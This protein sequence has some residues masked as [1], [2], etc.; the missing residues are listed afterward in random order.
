[1]PHQS[2]GADEQRVLAGFHERDK[3][4][5]AVKDAPLV[6]NEYATYHQWILRRR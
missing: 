3:G 1:V 2:A 4:F 5:T 6:N